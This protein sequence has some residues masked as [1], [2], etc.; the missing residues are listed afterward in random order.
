MSR[1]IDQL[2]DVSSSFTIQGFGSI[3]LQQQQK[4][5]H[6]SKSVSPRLI[7]ANRSTSW[8]HLA[9]DGGFREKKFKKFCQFRLNILIKISYIPDFKNFDSWV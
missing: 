7:G 2:G 4:H 3:K 1:V 9:R 5:Y 6:C 8:S